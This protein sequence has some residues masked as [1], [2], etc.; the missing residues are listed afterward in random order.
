MPLGTVRLPGIL[1]LKRLRSGRHG[2]LPDGHLPQ[3]IGIDTRAD[4]ALVI[5]AQ[6]GSY[7]AAQHPVYG[8]VSERFSPQLLPRS[9]VARR[10][11]LSQPNPAARFG[12][13]LDLRR[14]SGGEI[15]RTHLVPPCAA[16]PFHFFTSTTLRL[17]SS[18]AA[19]ASSPVPNLIPKRQY[20]YGSRLKLMLSVVG[21]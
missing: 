6:P 19:S 17:M 18:S 13:L 12:H 21:L 16:A 1:S 5:Q 2:V 14:Q 9:T 7:G 10:T 3:V 8:T 20:W 11:Y 15:V 4:T